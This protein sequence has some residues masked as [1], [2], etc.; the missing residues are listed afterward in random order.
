MIKRE[1]ELKPL[2]KKVKWKPKKEVQNFK[3]DKNNLNKDSF[4]LP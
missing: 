1:K 4:N 2:N 3:E